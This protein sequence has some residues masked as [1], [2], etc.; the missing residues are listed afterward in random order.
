VRQHPAARLGIKRNAR[1]APIS[2]NCR[3]RTLESPGLPGVLVWVMVILK[4]TF[5]SCAAEGDKANEKAMKVDY[6]LGAVIMASSHPLS[7]HKYPF[8]YC[9]KL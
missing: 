4:D 3:T 5:N 1:S 9:A 8:F 2:K 6:F 7:S